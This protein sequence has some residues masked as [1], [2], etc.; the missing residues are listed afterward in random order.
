MPS[1]QATTPPT[2]KRNWSVD[3]DKPTLRFALRML[4]DFH[5]P[6]AVV[7]YAKDHGIACAACFTC[8]WVPHLDE[9]CLLCEIPELER[10]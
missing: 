1:P 9:E 7:E 3:D 6:A 2:V 5:G 8:G 4:L 10:L